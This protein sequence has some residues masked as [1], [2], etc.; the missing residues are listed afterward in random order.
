MGNKDILRD[1]SRRLGAICLWQQRQVWSVSPTTS[2]KINLSRSLSNE[3]ENQIYFWNNQQRFRASS[4]YSDT[5]AWHIE[6]IL[7][8][9]TAFRASSRYSDTC[10]W[11]IESSWMYVFTRIPAWIMG[12]GDLAKMKED[13]MDSDEKAFT[14]AEC[15]AGWLAVFYRLLPSWV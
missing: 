11:H 3:W 5:C 2:H 10:A 15:F 9:P 7:K 12:K 4:R 14:K 1:D 13:Q 8:Q 6:S